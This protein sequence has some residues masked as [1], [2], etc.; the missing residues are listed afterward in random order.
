MLTVTSIRNATEDFLE[1]RGTVVMNAQATDYV[2]EVHNGGSDYLYETICYGRCH[3][4]W[5]IGASDCC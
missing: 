5:L 2:V 1:P 4:Q 3:R